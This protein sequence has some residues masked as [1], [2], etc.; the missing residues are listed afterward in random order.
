MTR[1][2]YPK[3]IHGGKKLYPG[4]SP[5]H[6]PPYRQ[7]FGLQE[8]VTASQWFPLYPA[9]HKQ[10]KLKLSGLFLHDP[11]FLHGLLAQA[12]P[13]SSSHNF[14]SRSIGQVHW[15]SYPSRRHCPPWKWL[16]SIRR[17]ILEEGKREG[18]GRDIYL[19]ISKDWASKDLVFSRI[20]HRWN[21][22]GICRS[23]RES[24]S[25][26]WG[27]T[28]GCRWFWRHRRWPICRCKNHRSRKVSAY[29]ANN[30]RWNSFPRREIEF[31][32]GYGSPVRR[33]RIC[34]D[35]LLHIEFWSFELWIIRV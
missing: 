26:T 35:I 29:T 6:K 17:R 7:G 21:H 16:I 11:P 1:I 31:Y 2:I 33:P 3:C 23:S 30:R 19:P 32:L 12:S 15:K 18:R 10:K 9:R 34:S 13:L 4:F 5:T 8:S 27:S 20:Y 24:F 28:L 25:A 22:P 14:P